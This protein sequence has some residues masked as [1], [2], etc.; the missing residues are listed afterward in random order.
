MTTKKT[1]ASDASLQSSIK[2]Q[3]FTGKAPKR[4]TADF[5]SQ[6]PKKEA[7]LSPVNLISHGN[8]REENA[9]PK[10]NQQRKNRNEYQLMLKDDQGKEIENLVLEFIPETKEIQIFKIVDEEKSK[11]TGILDSFREYFESIGSKSTHEPKSLSKSI[12]QNLSENTLPSLN[13]E[14]ANNTQNALF[15]EC[16][17]KIQPESLRSTQEISLAG[18]EVKHKENIEK[19]RKSVDRKAYQK[20]IQAGPINQKEIKNLMARITGLDNSKTEL[21]MKN[22]KIAINRQKNIIILGPKNLKDNQLDSSFSRSGAPLSHHKLHTEAKENKS[23]KKANDYSYK[24]AEETD[25]SLVTLRTYVSQKPPTK[26]DIIHKDYEHLN[27]HPINLAISLLNRFLEVTFRNK[28][29]TYDIELIA[30][31]S[32]TLGLQIAKKQINAQFFKNRENAQILKEKLMKYLCTVVNTSNEINI[33]TSACNTKVGQY[34]FYTCKG[35]NAI[36][37][38]SILKQR[39]WWSYGDKKDENLN[40]L[41]TQWYK[42]KF[43]A[44]LPKMEDGAK[45]A[46]D[47]REIRIS[48]HFEC[49]FHL[50]N[51]KA[52]FINLQRYY[53]AYGQ[54]PFATL[55]LTFHI[56]AGTSDPEFNKFA[57][58]Y[59][60]IENK[61]K[62]KKAKKGSKEEGEKSKP[63]ERNVWIIKP[64]EYSNRGCGIQVLHDFN[65][66][67]QMVS[68]SSKGART[69]I[70]QKY[71]EKPLLINKRKFDIRMYGLM[72][73]INGII[74]GYFYEEGYIRTSSKEYTLKNLANRA[75]HLTNDAV[76]KKYEDYGKYESGN[77]ISLPD[78]QKYLESTFPELDIDFYRDILPQIKVCIIKK[79]DNR[80]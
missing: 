55:P 13:I 14:K 18:Q 3:K 39:W 27:E 1:V 71:I 50:S 16:K 63:V 59:R 5:A 68:N 30:K 52:M 8:K 51:K 79:I 29:T 41:W 34:K 73:S 38:R 9:K 17:P 69:Y 64:G 19:Q 32:K 25:W 15:E 26:I 33:D 76:Q 45:K 24:I 60:D 2:S 20:D 77:K 75:I 74:K 28:D 35:N 70:V 80:K 66:I 65:E 43:I 61:I 22:I 21:W 72:T 46:Y 54:D 48:N 62:E 49:H 36:M 47:P 56:R 10:T 42:K 6:E 53:Q 57:E 12:D 44:G 58:Y 40:L 78:F 67:K 37:V 4:A 23:A 31:M 11:V 7:S